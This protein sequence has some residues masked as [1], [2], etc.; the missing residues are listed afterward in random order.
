MDSKSYNVLYDIEDVGDLSET[1][2]NDYCVVMEAGLNSYEGVQN[3][4]DACIRINVLYNQNMWAS[5]NYDALE[6]IEEMK[7]SGLLDEFEIP[8]KSSK[9]NKE[10]KAFIKKMIEKMHYNK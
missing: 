9:K 3:R 2:K 6:L 7:K 5:V 8:R 10:T 1:E 4:Q